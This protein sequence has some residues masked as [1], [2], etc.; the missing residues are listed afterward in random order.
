MKVGS[1][2]ATA[3][4][5]A[6]AGGASTSYA[7]SPKANAPAETQAVSTN[8]DPRSK[9]G[10]TRLNFLQKEWPE[11]LKQVADQTGS[12]LEMPE[13]PPGKF[14]RTDFGKHSREDACRILNR[15]LEKVGFRLVASNE[16]LI[17]QK[18]NRTHPEYPRHTVLSEKKEPAPQSN[19]V[20]KQLPADGR[21][22]RIGHEVAESQPRDESVKFQ[23]SNRPAIDIARQVH[24]TFKQRSHLENNG[25]NG[26]PAFVVDHF[27]E[28]AAK[29]GRPLFVIEIDTAGN[30]LLITAPASVQ[31]GL[32]QLVRGLDVNPLAQDKQPVLMAGDG[33]TAEV[34]KKLAQPLR[35]IAQAQETNNTPPAQAQPPAQPDGATQSA[36]LPAILGNLKGDVSIEA[37]TDLDLLI[38]RGNEKDVEQVMEVIKAIERMAQG[39]LPEIHLLTLQHVDSQSMATLLND[40][41]TKMTEL[42]ADNAQRNQAQ[43][44]VVP[45]VTPN[46]VL[47]LAPGSAMNS[48]LELADQLDQPI[49]PEHQVQIFRLAHAVATT[50]KEMLDSFYGTEPVG[51]GTRLKSVADSRTNS[52]I[53]QARPR[54]MTEIAKFIKD[55]DSEQSNAVSQLRVITLK[56]ATATELAE[57]LNNAFQSA[58]NPARMT[59]TG[60]QGGQIQGGG[61][62]NTTAKSVVLEFLME[63]GQQMIRSG[64]LNDIRFSAEPRTNALLVTASEQSFPLIQELVNILDRPSGALAEIKVFPLIHADAVDAQTLLNQ[65][66][67]ISQ[68]NQNQGGFGQ[69]SQQQNALGFELIGA[70]NSSSALVPI[71]FS[72]DTRSN[73][74]VAI[75]GGDALRIV[76]AVLLR[77]DAAQTRN[78]ETT[79]IKLRN[80]FA[81]DVAEAINEFL[82]SQR[83]L[84]TLDPTRISTSQLLEQ[85]IIVTAE[86]ITNSLIISATPTYFKQIEELVKKLDA[87]PP[88]VVIQAMIVEVELDN[89][90]EFGVELGVQD[91]ILFARSEISDLVTTTTSTLVPGVGTVNTTNVISQNAVPGFNWNNQPLGNNNGPG[92]NPSKIGTQGLTSFNVGRI[93]NDLGYGGM[94]LSASSD[95]VSALI[96]ALAA[97]RNLRVLSRPQVTVLDNQRAM[98]QVGQVVPVVNGVTILGT[99][100]VSPNV[101]QGEAGIILTVTPRISPEG[102]VVMEVAAEKS[103][104]RLNEGVP[105][106]VDATT[107]ATVTAPIKDVTTAS[108]Y[109]KVPDGQ[110]V[111]MGGLITKSDQSVERKVPWLG[112]LPL[113]GRAFRYDL[114]EHNRTELLIF[115]TPRIVHNDAS[116]ELIKTVEAGRL[117]FFQDD[118]ESLHGP[119]F[120]NPSGP[121]ALFQGAPPFD[122]PPIAPPTFD[123][124]NERLRLPPPV[125]A[126][127]ATPTPAPPV[128][129]PLAAEFPEQAQTVIT[130]GEP[131]RRP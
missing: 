72:V 88:Q 59:A 107:G 6:V 113:I 50:A 17:V 102:Q 22:Q 73:S 68:T 1:T 128:I 122:V 101:E 9:F 29:A 121:P 13:V 43:V 10:E 83:D 84:A 40:V 112:D 129:D 97:R 38:L 47:V 36:P 41:Y 16:R 115:L 65:L 119:I 130:L 61:A 18:I 27:D 62:Q 28:A 92:S 125:E 33:Q 49:D 89:T 21:I 64:L 4:C 31:V 45:V 57:F 15:D 124:S 96:R 94:V 90:D 67:N 56:S 78:R 131:P 63:D 110:T 120:G 116:M 23:P 87:E 2:L 8:K 11:V 105:I 48:I 108:T 39:S 126:P 25:P 46:A 30:Q 58:L 14:T 52:V 80:S 104:Y 69:S 20:P 19:S 70:Q 100:V 74:I 111:V 127:S 42:R 91:P 35:L 95:S 51:L 7:Q 99:G 75:G 71:R 85:E 81:P 86:P 118:V 114:Y 109:L 32:M 123:G 12:T 5:L 79:T 117:H 24:A 34:G 77:L 82:Q 37:M 98:V 26:F 93:N 106:Y 66:F 55:L 60:G 103:I 76:E 53:V 3:A 44:R 54:D